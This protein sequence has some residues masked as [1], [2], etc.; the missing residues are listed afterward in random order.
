MAESGL[1]SVGDFARLARVTQATLH[2]YDKIGLVSPVSRG[3]DNRYRYYS[4]RQLTHINVI[5]TLQGLGMT[6]TEIKA[7]KDIR[8]PELTDEIF[9]RQIELI[10]NK[11]AEWVGSKKLLLTLRQM[12]HSVHSVDEQEITVQYLP[13]EAII[14]GGLNDLGG[15]RDEYDALSDFYRIID[16]K[17]PALDLNYP[18][19]GVFSKERIERGDWNGPD[20]YYFYNPEGYDKRPA[21]LYA[22]GYTRGGYGQT[23]KLYRRVTAYIEQHGFEICGNAYEE[24][25]LNEICVANEGDYLIRVMIAVRAK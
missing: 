16:E 1:F 11:I 7:I 2:H 20:R 25:P 15:A 3:E 9:A 4:S 18:V 6:L 24:Y 8:T 13:A 22:I 21:A 10:E 12:I 17:Y 23:D 19:W 14:L 5:R